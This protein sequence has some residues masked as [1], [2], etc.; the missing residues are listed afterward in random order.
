MSAFKSDTN[1]A[2]IEAQFSHLNETKIKFNGFRVLRSRLNLDFVSCFKPD[3]TLLLIC[4]SFVL[5]AK[6]NHFN[7]Y[8]Y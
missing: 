5:F 2:E 6:D 7:N 4:I 3:K 8:M 1:T